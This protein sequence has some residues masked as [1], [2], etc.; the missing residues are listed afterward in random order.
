M[1]EKT[2]QLLLMRH[3]KSDWQ[4][5]VTSDFERPL[6]PRGQ[7]DALRMGRWLRAQGIVPER[8]LSSPAQRARQT[9]GAVREALGLEPDRLQLRDELYLAGRATLRQ[10]LAGEEDAVGPLLLVAHNPGLDDLVR[11]LA[12]SPPPLSASGKLMT[13]AAIAW[14][15]M[16]GGFGTL[17]AGRARLLALWRP[18]ELASWDRE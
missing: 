12:A 16:P 18:A 2:V 8:V 10:V 3:A 14:F 7:R 6:N 1:S 11:W 13:T 4:A 17:E 9:A 5:A 15:E